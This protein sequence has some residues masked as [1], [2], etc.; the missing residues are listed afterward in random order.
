MPPR[1]PH[2]GPHG[3]HGGPGGKPGAPPPP[4]AGPSN[5]KKAL[6]LDVLNFP[7]IVDGTR[8]VLVQFR[9]Y[10]WGGVTNYDD[11]AKHFEGQLD[12]IV[13]TVAAKNN[14]ELKEKYKVT[15]FPTIL[16]FHAHPS[17]KRQAEPA[18]D[19]FAGGATPTV[20]QLIEFVSEI[21][22]PNVK[23]LKSIARQFSKAATEELAALLHKAEAIAKD[24]PATFAE[25]ASVYIKSMQSIIKD[26]KDFV[27]KETK[28]LQGIVDSKSVDADKKK[29]FKQRISVLNV[30]K[31][32][33]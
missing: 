20:E 23:E 29:Q 10:S 8:T 14:E 30:F 4:S 7:K 5:F 22:N 19:T 17:G 33:L 3:P 12:L 26:G 25:T 18:Y 1:P 15:T 13:A 16:L 31:E 27:A 32:E 2:G 9:E 11:V 28:R 24:L 21:Q 6:E